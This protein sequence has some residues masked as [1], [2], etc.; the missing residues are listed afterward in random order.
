[1][2]TL[3]LQVSIKTWLDCKLSRSRPQNSAIET[4]IAHDRK[5][6]SK[7]WFEGIVV[8]SQVMTLKGRLSFDLKTYTSKHV[9][10]IVEFDVLR[11]NHFEG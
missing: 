5:A 4:R 11:A 10:S 2:E 8:Q 6:A 9:P 3:V 7:T 1:M